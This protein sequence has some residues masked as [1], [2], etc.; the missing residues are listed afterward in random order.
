MI[1]RYKAFINESKSNFY[2]TKIYRGISEEEYNNYIKGGELGNFFSTSK[3]FADDY[4]DGYLVECI[5]KTDNVFD[6]HL[7]ENIKVLF[8]EGFI[9]TDRYEDIDYENYDDYVISD[10]TWDIIENSDGVLDWIISRYDACYISEGGIGNFYIKD[11]STISDIKIIK[12]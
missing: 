1:K 8:D 3:Y 6:S 10:D 11:M 2:G 7:P 9:L 5:L 12:L 4:I